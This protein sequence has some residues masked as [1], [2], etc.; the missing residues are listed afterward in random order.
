MPSR[1]KGMEI[2]GGGNVLFEVGSQVCG[3]G[4]FGKAGDV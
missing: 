3:F 1:E 4:L 2:R